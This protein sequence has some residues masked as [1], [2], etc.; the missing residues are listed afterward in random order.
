MRQFVLQLFFLAFGMGLCAQ[1][2]TLS[3]II[4]ENSVKKSIICGGSSLDGSLFLANKQ[5]DVFQVKNHWLEKT[6]LNIGKTTDLEEFALYRNTFFLFKKNDLVKKGNHESEVLL[7]NIRTGYFFYKKNKLYFHSNQGCFLL[8]E[9]TITKADPPYPFEKNTIPYKQQST[10]QRIDNS[11]VLRNKYGSQIHSI[12]V[13][14]K[15]L[16]YIQDAWNNTYI[17][18]S[19][20]LYRIDLIH[21]KEITAQ[22]YPLYQTPIQTCAWNDTRLLLFENGKIY[23]YSENRSAPIFDRI[24]IKW[25]KLFAKAGTL[26]LLDQNNA[27]YWA[28]EE[29]VRKIDFHGTLNKKIIDIAIHDQ[30]ISVLLENGTIIQSR[31][32]KNASDWIWTPFLFN[33]TIKSYNIDKITSFKNKLWGKSTQYGL[34]NL[35]NN[36]IDLLQLPDGNQVISSWN[37]D[38]DNLY[39]L[40]SKNQLFHINKSEKLALIA[41]LN[42]S[43]TWLIDKKPQILIKDKVIYKWNQL[44]N[45]TSF[46]T[47]IPDY[48]KQPVWVTDRY[49]YIPTKTKIWEYARNIQEQNEYSPILSYVHMDLNDGSRKSLKYPFNQDTI[50]LN[51]DQWPIRLSHDI[52][53]NEDPRDLTIS[54]R[55]QKDKQYNYKDDITIQYTGRH[56]TPTYIIRSKENEYIQKLPVLKSE[57]T[58]EEKTTFPWIWISGLFA[59]LLT[60]GFIFFRWQS[61][62]QKKKIEELDIKNRLLELEQKSLQLQMNPHFLFNA[63][64]GIQGMIALN[65]GKEA[66]KYLGKLAL[67]M[68]SMLNHSRENTVSIKSELALLENYMDIEKALHGEKWNYTFD[69]ESGLD[70]SQSI[71]PMMIQPFLENAIKHAFKGVT[72][73][74]MIRLSLRQKGRRLICE[75]EDNGVG[76]DTTKKSNKA[77]QSLAL[78]VIKSRLQWLNQGTSLE[79]FKIE[80]KNTSNQSGT[81]IHIVIPI[82]NE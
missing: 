23:T 73:Q 64:N 59:G 48:D 28:T 78:E 60:T 81:I 43:Y 17:L 56:F 76:F 65:K 42:D 71:P 82:I 15:D 21:K 61:N 9:D 36:P 18:E 1:T 20:Q 53:W 5:G 77:H 24:E 75:V 66:R 22:G 79:E 27:L 58:K 7:S 39:I 72:Y 16:R 54:I 13:G 37:Q 34:I 8:N 62:R 30:I 4:H 38:A 3:P 19:G 26:F 51:E 50:Y 63:I 6:K 35:S 55:S 45:T 49:V 44:T 10:L 70:L 57:K 12:Q 46:S 47:S 11:L 33:H 29:K 80:N 68:R 41:K 67:L 52:N 32:H 14:N 31:F 25:K 2:L 40:T 74:G 69:I